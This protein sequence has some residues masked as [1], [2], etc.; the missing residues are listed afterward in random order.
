MAE[1]N[2]V[3]VDVP[4]GNEFVLFEWQVTE[5]DTGGAPE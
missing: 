3:Q 4:Q 2:P 5:D 1:L